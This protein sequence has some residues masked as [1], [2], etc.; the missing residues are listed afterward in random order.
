MTSSSWGFASKCSGQGAAREETYSSPALARVGT[1]T[2]G[3]WPEL[4]DMGVGWGRGVFIRLS[5]SP[6]QRP[7]PL[8]ASCLEQ[9]CPQL[10][11]P[12]GALRGIP[13]QHWCH[14]GAFRGFWRDPGGPVEGGV[15][16]CRD[17]GPCWMWEGC[18]Q[19]R[20]GIPGGQRLP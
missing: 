20:R 5:G 6:H 14:R 7:L 16:C 17:G 1:G 4:L 9:S 3:L 11:P 19:Q 2:R 12:H 13:A 18:S 15:Q 10:A 8:S